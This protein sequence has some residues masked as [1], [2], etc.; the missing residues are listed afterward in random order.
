MKKFK[1]N[2]NFNDFTNKC[3][4]LRLHEKT[5]WIT[6]V[7]HLNVQCGMQKQKRQVC[8]FSCDKGTIVTS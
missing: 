6:Q 8:Q 1:V 3:G 4:L 5:S 2:D 7:R